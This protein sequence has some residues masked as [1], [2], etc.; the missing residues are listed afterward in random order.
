VGSKRA[1]SWHEQTA[2]AVVKIPRALRRRQS[3]ANPQGRNGPRERVRLP[4]KGKL[5]REAPGTRAVWNKTAKRRGPRRTA[6]AARFSSEPRAARTV[7]RG[8][9]PEDGTGGSVEA[10]VTHVRPRGSA[11]RKGAPGV[12]ASVGA[13]TPREADPQGSGTV[14]LLLRRGRTG[15]RASGRRRSPSTLERHRTP[16][17][18][19][20]EP[21]FYGKGRRGRPR[22]RRNGEGGAPEANK[23]L[24]AGH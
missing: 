15:E 13:R 11:W 3:N 24:L 22:D 19:N 7:E 4:G 18:K 14:S 1:K 16:R 6:R 20:V 21:W 8:K 23:A 5:W 9:N 12:K 2:K 17:G 10:S